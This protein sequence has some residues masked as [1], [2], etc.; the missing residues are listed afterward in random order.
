MTRSPNH[1]ERFVDILK[2]IPIFFYACKQLGI[3]RTTLYR[4]MRSNPE[5]ADKVKEAL[6]V[7]TDTI[8]D[9]AEMC[10][11]QKVQDRD[12]KTCKYWLQH[13]HHTYIPKRT[14]YVE[15][16]TEKRILRNGIPC[17][18]CGHVEHKGFEPGGPDFSKKKNRKELTKEILQNRYK[19]EMEE[20]Y[21]RKFY[22]GFIFT[23]ESKMKMWDDAAKDE[24]QSGI[25]E[26][27]PEQKVT[28]EFIEPNNKLDTQKPKEQDIAESTPKKFGGVQEA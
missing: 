5:F 16:Q 1:R 17:R 28:E 15:P 25:Q 27:Q 21:S 11:I 20:E 13:H 12:I 23:E 26:T 7:G 9:V 18:D 24:Y 8:N 3:S 22:K 10:I 19:K 4:W 14:V 6:K 2:E